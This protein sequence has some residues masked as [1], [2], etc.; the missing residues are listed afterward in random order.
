MVFFFL[1]NFV[2]SRAVSPDRV[3]KLHDGRQKWMVK[4]A[5]HDHCD[6]DRQDRIPSDV[7]N[8][9][10][11]FQDVFRKIVVVLYTLVSD[12]HKETNIDCF[13]RGRFVS[14]L[15]IEPSIYVC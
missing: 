5:D 6:T 9:R 15:K 10:M 3:R 14:I 1:F 7:Y 2:H 8:E 13:Y 4:K 12:M 11:S